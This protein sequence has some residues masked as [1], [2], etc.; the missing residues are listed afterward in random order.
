MPHVFEAASTGRA[1]CRGCKQLI[2]RG[3]LRFGES[4]PNQFGEGEVTHWFHPQ[5]A[6]WKRPEPILETL[7]ASAA[8]VPA[9]EQLERV[10]QVAITHHRLQRIDGAERA[11]T[12][13]AKCRQCHEA[14]AKGGWRIR[15]VFHEE[16]MF[17]P[18]GF[19]HLA[20]REANFETGDVLEAVLHFSPAL[21]GAEREALRAELA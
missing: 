6:A 9:R 4:L 10:S 11:P 7:K 15:L 5:C 3:E 14:I 17:S 8:E 20:C 16:G 1:K 19:I 12:G 21:E 13:Q 18:G 2:A